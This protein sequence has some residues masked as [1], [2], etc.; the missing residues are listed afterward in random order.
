MKNPSLHIIWTTGKN[1]TLPDANSQNTP[2]KLITRKATVEIQQN[3]KLFPTKDETLPQLVCKFAV[4]MT[5]K[6]YKP[7]TYNISH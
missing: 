1:L 7:T 6:V 4:T 3:I 5:L 2:P